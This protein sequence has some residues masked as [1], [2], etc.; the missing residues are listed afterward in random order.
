[1]LLYQYNTIQYFGAAF[2]YR[3]RPRYCFLNNGPCKPEQTYKDLLIKVDSE[4]LW[5]L[6]TYKYFLSCSQQIEEDSL[7]RGNQTYGPR[8][9][10]P[11]LYLLHH[12]RQNI[13]LDIFPFPILAL[14]SKVIFRFNSSHIRFMT[15]PLLHF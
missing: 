2:V 4:P 13:Y 3:V 14:S 9:V 12:S 7:C 11:T 8:C 1:M 5:V 15:K 10:R 6:M